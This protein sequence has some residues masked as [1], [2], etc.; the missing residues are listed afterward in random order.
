MPNPSNTN[1]QLQY[2]TPEA[3]VIG[4][5]MFNILGELVLEEQLNA[6][7]GIHVY[8]IPSHR[9]NNGIYTIKVE[10]NSGVD[11]QSIQIIR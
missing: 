2:F 5:K 3:K 10:T 1:A 11:V 9:F 4:L 6:T 7:E 8:E